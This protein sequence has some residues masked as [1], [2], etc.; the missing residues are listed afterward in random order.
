MRVLII[1][2]VS[3]VVSF[4]FF[5]G[6]FAIAP[7]L[8]LPY[9]NYGRARPSFGA[10]FGAWDGT[11]YR[12][13]ALH[14]YPSQ[15]PL[16]ATGH[17]VQNAWAFL[18]MYS[19]VTRGLMLVT[20]LGFVPAGIIVSVLFGALASGLLFRMLST[21]IGETKALWSVAFFCFGPMSFIFDMNYADSMFVALMFACVVLII[22]RRYLLV[23]PVGLV[24]AFTRPG[25]LAISATIG[26]LCIAQ[27]VR[28]ERV[29][30]GERVRMIVSAATVAAAGFAWPVIAGAV[31]GDK[32]A[33]FD[34]ELSWWTLMV[35]RVQFIPF[36]PWFEQFY[37]FTGIIGPFLVIGIIVGFIVWLARREMRVLGDE[38]LAYS[39][40]YGAYLL[41]TFLPQQSIARLLLPMA[42]LFGTPLFTRSPRWRW[43]ILIAF[44]VLQPGAIAALW[45]IYPP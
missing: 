11:Y 8:K 37:A 40:S 21:R 39:G 35:G 14:G 2:A 25:A 45:F 3:R 19:W 28:H 22:Q 13:I 42:P 17:V 24:A 6:V 41:A 9:A 1:Y 43:G 27:L 12:E 36:A 34:T 4:G 33:Y 26:I 38:L 5:A 23:I 29:G 10:F 30:V 16:D 20:N 15:L 31:T 32:N 7:L 18:P 44:L